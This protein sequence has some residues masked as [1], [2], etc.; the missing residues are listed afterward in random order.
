MR[1]L[2]LDRW[3]LDEHA[4]GAQ[5]LGICGGYQMLGKVIE[6]PDGVESATP[7][8]LPSVYCRYA[9]CC[10]VTRSQSVFEPVPR[11]ESTLM[12]TRYTLEIANHLR[13]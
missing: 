3:L 12:P 4:R 2:G 8:C 6:D 7:V 1:A 11:M 9:Q 5:V 13:R 10:S